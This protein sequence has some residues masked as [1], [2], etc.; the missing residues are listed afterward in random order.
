[1]TMNNFYNKNRW[2]GKTVCFLGDSITEGYGV[3]TGERYFDLL[4]NMIG[5]KS[6]CYGVGGARYMDI[7]GQI[8][9]MKQDGVKPDAIFVFAGTNDYADLRPLGKWYDISDAEVITR[10]DEA[11][12]AVS[13]EMRPRRSFSF[14]ISTFRGGINTV[15]CELRHTYPHAAIVLMTP[16]HRGFAEF[17]EFALDNIHFPDNYPNHIGLHIDDY[18]SVVKEAAGVWATELIDLYSVSG[19]FP[20]FDEGADMFVSKDHDRL[21]PEKKGHERMAEVIARK[22]VAIAPGAAE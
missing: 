14:D 19:L 5:I 2:E 16:L 10:K 9:R 15:L 17:L 22:M 4:E 6:M 21:H 11:G 20:C 18:V 7:P 1:M 3:G 13:T 12:N 8:A